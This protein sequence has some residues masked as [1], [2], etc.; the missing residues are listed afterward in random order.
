[1]GPVVA[2]LEQRLAVVFTAVAEKPANMLRDGPTGDRPAH[3]LPRRVSTGPSPAYPTSS[4][5]ARL[6]GRQWCPARGV[7]R[8]VGRLRGSMIAPFGRRCST[9]MESSRAT[10]SPPIGRSDPRRPRA[11][12]PHR[13]TGRVA[14]PPARRVPARSCPGRAAARVRAGGVAARLPAP[15]PRRTKPAS[16]PI[17]AWTVGRGAPGRQAHAVRLRAGPDQGAVSVG[18]R[19]RRR[20]AIER[21]PTKARAATAGTTR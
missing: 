12:P 17:S 8:A 10:C 3:T 13:L 6:P 4:P 14:C 7:F 9:G 18:R 19:S 20:A 1:M 2:A 16:R 5:P 11:A 15:A 21:R